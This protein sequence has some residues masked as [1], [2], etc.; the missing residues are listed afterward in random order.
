MLTD[1]RT[2]PEVRVEP[3]RGITTELGIDSEIGR[4][5]QAIV[6]RPGSELSHLD[7][8]GHHRPTRHAARWADKARE[9]HDAF[10]EVL[11]G[12]G[13]TVHYF[14]ELLAQTLGSPPARDFVLD[15][16]CASNHLGFDVTAAMGALANDCDP[17]TL[18]DLLIGG[19]A[20]SDLVPRTGKARRHRFSGDD[21]V[22]PPLPNILFQRDT[23]AWLYGGMTINP[24]ATAARHQ[25]SL[26]TRA[27]Y[28][29]HPL[30]ADA[31]ITGYYGD[32]DLDHQSATLDGGDIQV[33]GHGALLIGMGKRTTPLAAELLARELFR[34][35]A[36][37]VVVAVE[38][39]KSWS[40]VPFDSVLTMVDTAT[41]VCSP[42]LDAASLTSWLILPADPD[43]PVDQGVG[44]LHIEA[45]ANLFDTIAEALGVDEVRILSASEDGDT[46]DHRQGDIATNLLALAPGVVVAHD[47]NVATNA[48]LR[49]NGFDVLATP[50]NA[51]G[52]GRRG[53]RGLTC[54]IQRDVTAV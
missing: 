44:E 35:H 47:D 22:I 17:V 25:E 39:P 7:S 6:H 33:L 4:L 43:D 23:S 38:M 45:R 12:R 10:A 27:I 21:F 30:F 41:F 15:R 29:F 18:A 32:D 37:E 28:R 3:N 16:V 13:V 36:A 49:E 51:L 53:P 2:T 8:A 40:P 14:A 31:S 26:Y 5:R 11:R 42:H 1:A 50:S 46:A 9:E 54:P 20:K 24:M 19:V 52:R 48:M 34:T